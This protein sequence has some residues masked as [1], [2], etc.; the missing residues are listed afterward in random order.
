[1]TTRNRFR[2]EPGLATTPVALALS[3]I[4]VLTVAWVVWLALY[5]QGRTAAP[6]LAPRPASTIASVEPPETPT[7]TRTVPRAVLD[8]NARMRLRYAWLV[9]S[10]YARDRG[11]SFSG[12]TPR[13]AERVLRSSGVDVTLEGEG[14]LVLT[15]FD[16]SRRAT[17]G[18]V[19]IRVAQGRNLLLVTRSRSG[20]AF[21]YVQRGPETGIGPGDVHRVAQCVIRW[22]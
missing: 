13:I 21:C 8:D 14:R 15:R 22:G 19:S 9:A 4:L 17:A 18:V 10:D 11:P 5:Q 12:L 7:P 1:M 3:A 20:T 16:T 2:Q 6:R